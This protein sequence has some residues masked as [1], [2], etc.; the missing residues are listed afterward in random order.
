[1][2]EHPLR[3]L[4]QKSGGIVSEFI[5]LVQYADMEARRL[6]IDRIDLACALRAIERYK[7]EKIK[8]LDSERLR[9]LCRIYAEK[10]S[11]LPSEGIRE[12]VRSELQA[13]LYILYYEDGG[14]WYW[15]HPVLEDFLKEQCPQ[16]NQ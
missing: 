4:V 15:T 14:Q 10:P 7:R 1:V 5:Y 16:K 6:R 12:E 11:V 8:G 3:P 2:D 9:F 13:T